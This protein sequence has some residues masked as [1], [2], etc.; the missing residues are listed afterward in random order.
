VLFSA[1]QT[2]PGQY[3]IRLERFADCITLPTDAREAELQRLCER[4]AAWLEARCREAPFNWFNFYDFWAT[5]P[6]GRR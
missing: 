2:R 4:Y 6:I 5:E 3:R 1:L